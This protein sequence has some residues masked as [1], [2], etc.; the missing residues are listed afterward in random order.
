MNG[1]WVRLP[2]GA[3]RQWGNAAPALAGRNRVPGYPCDPKQQGSL[4][5]RRKTG[6]PNAGESRRGRSERRAEAR[7]G[8]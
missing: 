2:V 5:H 3:L 6:L 7:S 4:W 8:N 1:G